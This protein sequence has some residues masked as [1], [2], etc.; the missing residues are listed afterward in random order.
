MGGT[1][2]PA[3]PAGGNDLS[4][5]HHGWVSTL[6]PPRDPEAAVGVLVVEL[7]GRLGVP[8]TVGVCLDLLGGADRLGH[9]PELA[10]LTGLPFEAGSATLDPDRWRDYWV[11]TWGARGLLYVWTDDAAPGVVAGLGDEH[12]RPAEMCLKVA[13]RR[14]LGEAGPAAVGFLAHALPRVR[15]QALRT[16]GA[17]GDTEHVEAV[18]RALGDDHPDV[19]RQAARALERMAA[20]LDLVE[21]QW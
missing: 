13:T 21:E 9:L 4:G 12:W 3:R 20:R 6:P 7:A 10:Y 11:R 14:E 5:R 19:R 8:A 16:L 18:R 15:A 2:A 17:A 1:V